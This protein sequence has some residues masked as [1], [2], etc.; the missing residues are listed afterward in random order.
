MGSDLPPSIFKPGPPS[1][2]V[3]HVHHG[4]KIWA[5]CR[6]VIQIRVLHAIKR[7]IER[8]NEDHAKHAELQVILAELEALLKIPG[9]APPIDSKAMTGTELLISSYH[10][11]LNAASNILAKIR[12][13][14]TPIYFDGVLTALG[15]FMSENLY[16]APG[17]SAEQNLIRLM[18]ASEKY[19]Q[20][21]SDTQRSMLLNRGV[22]ITDLLSQKSIQ[23]LILV[24][25]QPALAKQPSNIR[26]C[27]SRD[28]IEKAKDNRA[29]NEEFTTVVWKLQAQNYHATDAHLVQ[30]YAATTFAALHG[31]ATHLKGQGHQQRGRPMH[32]SS[33]S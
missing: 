5:Q 15:K 26:E 25:L 6:E 13:L 17:D 1:S 31:P 33:A 22:N 19:A 21:L 28:I 27:L 18:K 8:T 20:S 12:S 3:F 11:G 16:L 30:D 10:P 7:Y 24:E 9:F 4:L 14:Y 2:R 29:S 23:N 32:K